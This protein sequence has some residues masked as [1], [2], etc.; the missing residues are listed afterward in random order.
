MTSQGFCFMLASRALRW[1]QGNTSASLGEKK[2]L[3]VALAFEAT[4]SK[5]PKPLL[6]PTHNKTEF[7]AC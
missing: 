4:D 2:L 1:A 3:P 6:D 5:H 7:P